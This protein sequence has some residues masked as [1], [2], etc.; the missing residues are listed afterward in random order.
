MALRRPPPLVVSRIDCSMTPAVPVVDF[1]CDATKSE[2]IS[3]GFIRGLGART[4]GLGLV[5]RIG[6]LGSRASRGIEAS[7]G[8][9]GERVRDDMELDFLVVLERGTDL[10]L[11]I[12]I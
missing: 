10:L 1:V 8:V 2:P 3:G 11:A 5:L 6:A 12:G 7:V 4:I 9:K